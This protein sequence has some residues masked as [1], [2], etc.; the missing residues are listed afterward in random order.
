MYL[1]IF[2]L[3]QPA[4]FHVALIIMSPAKAFLDYW[5]LISSLIQ[6]APFPFNT[7]TFCFS[8][9]SKSQIPLEKCMY[10]PQKNPYLFQSPPFT[11]TF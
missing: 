6:Y 10:L 7:A 3:P 1:S 9:F 5:L 11:T 2:S 4:T 8:I